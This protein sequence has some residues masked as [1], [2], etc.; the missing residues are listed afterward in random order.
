MKCH[1]GLKKDHNGRLDTLISNVSMLTF[2]YFSQLVWEAT[3]CSSDI[4]TAARQCLLAPPMLN[5]KFIHVLLLP[6]H[7]KLFPRSVFLSTSPLQR[8]PEVNFI[9]PHKYTPPVQYGGNA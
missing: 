3:L 9:P 5:P 7:L 1:C 6:L 2:N 4:I 8:R